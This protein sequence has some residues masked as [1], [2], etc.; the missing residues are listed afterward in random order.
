[1]DNNETIFLKPC[2]G[3]SREEI[4]SGH[5]YKALTEDQWST[6]ENLGWMTEEEAVSRFGERVEISPSS[7]L[8]PGC[9]RIL[10]EGK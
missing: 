6:G 5:I 7:A 1:M 2:A 9:K 4:E 3:L 10:Q 8:C